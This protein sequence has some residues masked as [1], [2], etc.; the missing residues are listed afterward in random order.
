MTEVDTWLS[1]SAAAARLGVHPTT[2]RRWAD[3]GQVPVSWTPGGHRRF[4]A[5]DINQ[6]LQRPQAVVVSPRAH[7]VEEV[8]ASHTL[9]VTRQTLA[10]AALRQPW[11][12]AFDQEERQHNRVLGQQ[13]IALIMQTIA[14]QTGDEAFLEEAGRIGRAY[15]HSA[16]KAGLPLTTALQAALFFRDMLTLSVLHLPE[17]LPVQSETTLR[18]V[19][20]INNLLNTVHLAVAAV[21]DDA[22]SAALHRS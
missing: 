13:L 5:G 20:K 11:L 16:Q 8:W 10:G 3:N 4:A 9:T 1:L 7:T 21:Y 17:T 15:G 22:H 14:S 18:L 12:G 2:L 19:S 6:L